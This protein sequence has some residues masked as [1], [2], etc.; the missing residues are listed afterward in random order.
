M[1]TDKHR[2]SGFPG[3]DVDEERQRAELRVAEFEKYVER[4]TPVG[5]LILTFMR[6]TGGRI[7]MADF[8]SVVPSAIGREI[9]PSTVSTAQ[10]RTSQSL[11]LRP[12]NLV[13]FQGSLVKD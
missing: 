2:R 10:L 12:I 11:H 6:L 8:W 1:V 4:D 5:V 7:V 9:K 13:V 3:Q